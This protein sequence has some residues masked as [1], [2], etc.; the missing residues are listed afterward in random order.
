M[1]SF[2]WA[3]LSPSE[4]ISICKA[5]RARHRRSLTGGRHHGEAVKDGNAAADERTFAAFC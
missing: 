5:R 2:C 1:L 4:H 3:V